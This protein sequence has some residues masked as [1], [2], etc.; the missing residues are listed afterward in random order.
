TVAA[1]GGSGINRG[2]AGTIY[3]KARNSSFGALVI[4]NGGQP[5]TNTSWLLIGTIDLTVTGGAV[6]APPVS[7]AFNNLVIGPSSALVLSGEQSFLTVHGDALI[8]PGG[9]IT[10]DGA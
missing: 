6:V 10:A 4:D 1:R 8:Q 9:A 7:Q 2:G 3:S 5:G